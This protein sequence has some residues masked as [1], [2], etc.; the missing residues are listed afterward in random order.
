[1]KKVI[2][3][4]LFFLV[5]SYGY[6]QDIIIL[7]SGEKIEAKILEVTS[8]YVKYKKFDFQNGPTISLLKGYISK[9]HY[10]N[11]EKVVFNIEKSNEPYRDSTFFSS[12]NEL[13][14]QG[15][16]DAET[17]YIKYNRAST[18]TLITSIIGGLLG[19]IPAIACASTTPKDKNLD[20]PDAE[21]FKKLDYRRGY[22]QKAKQIKKKK[23][24][25]NFWVGG[26]VGTVIS[27]ILSSAV[28][29]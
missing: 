28:V 20:Y 8:N 2:I 18:G 24:W 11:G 26:T 5:H 10:E 7:R 14:A 1:M 23:V 17:Y 22:I 19:L 4:V 3:L 27:S 12:T 25:T 15:Q 29:Y 16:I 21:L 13:Y 6:S 9:I